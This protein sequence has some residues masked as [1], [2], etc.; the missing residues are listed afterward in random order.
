MAYYLQIAR[1]AVQLIDVFEARIVE[2]GDWDEL[3]A[4]VTDA[5]VAYVE[6]M[7]T[8]GQVERLAEKCSK[9]AWDLPF[10]ADPHPV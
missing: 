6:G 4:I 9:A 1:A 5:E 7:V 10:R 3:R 8:G 2:A